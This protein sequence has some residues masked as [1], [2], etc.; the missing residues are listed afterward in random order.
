[1]FQLPQS[2]PDRAHC[3]VKLVD[4][5]A[6]GLESRPEI[7]SEYLLPAQ[8]PGNT[9]AD[10]AAIPMPRRLHLSRLCDVHARKV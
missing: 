9:L 6:Q 2:I 8:D 3:S 10:P 7:V 5:I 1:M 4:A